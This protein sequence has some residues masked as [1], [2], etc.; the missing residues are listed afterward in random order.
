MEITEVWN[1]RIDK[2]GALGS[3]LG[4]RAKNVSNVKKRKRSR[5]QNVTEDASDKEEGEGSDSYYIYCEEK[6]SETKWNDG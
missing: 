2:T 5:K 6:Y 3:I 4:R 1:P